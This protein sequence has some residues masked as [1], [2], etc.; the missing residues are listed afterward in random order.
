MLGLALTTLVVLALLGIGVGALVAPRVASL[1]FGILLED[2]RSLAFLRA[3]G[4]RDLVIGVL[5]ALLLAAGRR[6]LLAFALAAS[7]GVALLDFVVVTRDVAPGGTPPRRSP[8]LLHA[9]GAL[10]LLA[11]ACVV[12]LGW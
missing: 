7:A 4:V 3:M 1:Q 10:G 8:R 5:L 9:C 2:T 12:A 6:D 11:A